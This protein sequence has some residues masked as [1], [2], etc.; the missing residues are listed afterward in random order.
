[1]ENA[2]R[3]G[4][5]KSLEQGHVISKLVKLPLGL[6][7]G[8]LVPAL[9]ELHVIFKSFLEME[10][11]VSVNVGN[12]MENAQMVVGRGSKELGVAILMLILQ[13]H[14]GLVSVLQV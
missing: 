8:N 7:P 11:N 1:M 6:P 4:G 10:Q 2:L 14:C 9:Q 5:K 13:D 3:R 12:Q